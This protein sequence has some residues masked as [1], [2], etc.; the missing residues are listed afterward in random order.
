MQFQKH[1]NSSACFERI[2]KDEIKL[3]GNAA[4][5]QHVPQLSYQRLFLRTWLEVLKPMAICCGSPGDAA[6][7]PQRSTAVSTYHT[8]RVLSGPSKLSIL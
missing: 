1:Y 2:F 4:G 5:F 7:S 6:A 8:T 3:F